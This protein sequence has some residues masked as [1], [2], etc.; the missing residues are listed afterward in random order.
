MILAWV[1][2]VNF[3]A[4]QCATLVYT[5]E[6]QPQTA[7]GYTYSQGW[8]LNNTS[9]CHAINYHLQEWY[10]YTSHVQVS[11][12]GINWDNYTG[13][14][15]LTLGTTS[16]SNQSDP[17]TVY[18]NNSDSAEVHFNFTQC[19]TGKHY[20]IFFDI[21][22]FGSNDPLIPLDEG[23]LWTSFYVENTPPPPTVPNLT[24]YTPSVQSQVIA[25]HNINLSAVIANTGTAPTGNFAIAEIR[26]S[27]NMTLSDA[28]ELLSDPFIASISPGATSNLYQTLTI[29]ASTPAGTYYIFINVDATDEVDETNEND[30]VTYISIEVILS[31]SSLPNLVPTNIFLPS[32]VNQ[33]QNFSTFFKTKNASNNSLSWTYFTG[34]IYL[35]TNNSL[36]SNDPIVKTVTNPYDLSPGEIDFHI[37][38][39]Y[40]NNLSPGNYW[41]IYQVDT[42]N[43]VNETTNDDNV[44]VKPFKVRVPCVQGG[45]TPD[46]ILSSPEIMEGQSINVSNNT[47][48][49]TSYAWN[50]DNTS[51]SSNTNLNNIALENPG[52]AAMTL[53]AYDACDNDNTITEHVKV[54]PDKTKPAPIDARSGYNG[55]SARGL[56]P[57]DLATGAFV[58]KIDFFTIDDFS[59]SYPVSAYYTSTSNEHTGLGHKW[60][61]SFDVRLEAEER[62]YIAHW[63][64]GHKDYYV[65]Y[66]DNSAEPLYNGITDTLYEVGPYI[67]EKPNG[68]KYKFTSGD[69]PL[70]N[71]IE[72]RYGNLIYFSYYSSSLLRK[73]TFPNGKWIEYNYDV[74]GYI[75]S[76]EADDGRE[77]QFTID[78]TNGNLIQYTNVKG[79]AMSM[80]YDASH[81]LVSKTDFKGTTVLANTYDTYNRVVSQTDAY[82]ETFHAAYNTP[83]ADATTVTDPA[84]N[85]TIYY[86][87]NDL[88][89]Y[90]KTDELGFSTYTNYDNVVHRPNS[91]TD[92][93][94]NISSIIFDEIGNPLHIIN[95]LGDSISTTLGEHNLP[96]SFTN[97]L[98]GITSFT[99]D[100]EGNPLTTTLPNGATLASTFSGRG[101]L[102]TYTTPNGYDYS[103]AYDYLGNVTEMTTPSGIINFTRDT[104]GRVLTITDR[105]NKTIEFVWDEKNIIEV[106]DAKGNSSYASYDANDNLLYQVNRSSDTTFYSYDLRDRLVKITNALGEE[107][108]FVYN[109]LDLLVEVIDAKNNTISYT[110]NARKELVSMTND[111][112]TTQYAYN[113]VGDLTSYTTSMGN[114]YLTS[115]DALHR[116]TLTSNPLGKIVDSLTYNKASQPLKRINGSGHTTTFNYTNMG[117]LTKAT[118]N[119]GASNTMTLDNEGN[120]LTLK[121]ANGHITTF[122]YNEF[123]QAVT[124]QTPAGRTTTMTVNNEGYITQ[125][126]RPD[127]T[128]NSFAYDDNYNII[129]STFP[130]DVYSWVYNVNDE[131]TA[132]TN[133]NGTTSF[134][135][136]ALSRI[137][138]TTDPFGNEIFKGYDEVS[139]NIYTVYPSGDTLTTE[140]NSL[141]LATKVSDWLGNYSIREYNADGLLTDITNSNGTTTQIGY[142]NASQ[143][144]SYQN[145]LADESI[146]N[147][148][149][150][151]RLTGGNIAQD[152]AIVPLQPDFSGRIDTYN[153]NPD[154]EIV[155]TSAKNFTHNQ[156]GARSAI[157][158]A[159]NENITWGESDLV[160]SYTRNGEN[161]SNKYNP[162][163]QRIEKNSNS[164][165]T[166]YALDISS[167]LSQIL[168]E[169]DEVGYTNATNIYAPDGLA[170]R[171]DDNGEA[172]FFHFDY[173]G[174][175]KGLTDE[176]GE[177]TDL[178]AH[179][180]FGDYLRHSGASSQPFIFQGKYGITHEGAG[181]YQVRAREYDATTGLFWSKDALNAGLGNT[182]SSTYIFGLNNPLSFVDVDGNMPLRQTPESS[183]ATARVRYYD[184]TRDKFSYKT[185][186]VSNANIMSGILPRHEIREMGSLE[187]IISQ[188]EI[189]NH[190][191]FQGLSEG[192]LFGIIPDKS[193]GSYF[194]GAG[195]NVSR[196][197]G[198][199]LGMVPELILSGNKLAAEFATRIQP[200]K[201]FNKSNYR[202]NLQ[203]LTGNSGHGFD[204]HHIFPQEF[205]VLFQNIGININNPNN[206]KWWA[207]NSHRKNAKAYNQAWS[208]FFKFNP[209]P[210]RRQIENFGTHIMNLFGF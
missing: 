192:F 202:Y 179:S 135:L 122:T 139:N 87:D 142:D 97:L 194:S 85:T 51:S 40:T 205:Q 112:G 113:A 42:H 151:T 110:Y 172:S 94:G 103:L 7:T 131:M 71:Q 101:Q 72:D 104:E 208:S 190:C 184:T 29:D 141:G 30:N 21:Y 105:E 20:K 196:N 199:F 3:L 108:Q 133:V 195:C 16:P 4:A 76:I 17:F 43:N 56:D 143:I 107:T 148:H 169:Q 65:R 111:L 31:S 136:D 2:S 153:H 185:I 27:N 22:P 178:Y 61:Y 47:T 37:G 18:A 55:N 147:Q 23:R 64:D 91:F 163:R 201:T 183:T 126:Q 207:Y 77:V 26:L 198:E 187:H 166:R 189:A 130:E 203:A 1:A 88:R 165:T 13:A 204:A 9:S 66:Q 90:K 102:L 180:P 188:A 52:S 115:Y 129:S 132:M 210:T 171:I 144:V 176:S 38:V 116:P 99:R 157:S 19:E 25:G 114:T 134:E 154:D 49:A 124:Q 119:L 46:F 79:D 100:S 24:V 161:I 50:I 93:L 182:Q 74:N 193:K 149:N 59:G 168:E 92:E 138:K 33:G 11:D 60:T 84:G 106:V 78:G 140:F 58:T 118:D 28:D 35:S 95:A 53:T 160:T 68:T 128:I 173:I 159:T 5:G 170:W 120:I 69:Q 62:R 155:S 67:I 167:Y 48:N 145:L 158:G 137:T 34:T 8:N 127:G 63:P 41:M 10:D 36:D 57:V 81:N 39:S 181:H 45:P 6:Y 125:V 123:G 174:H 75:T 98:G 121:D 109:N 83:I 73:V 15:N 12:D 206:L 86:H 32:V 54:R 197:I 14:Y 156:N 150:L 162:L 191:F 186:Q 82:N 200:L 96:L 175:T 164:E 44:I 152:A 70:L 80:V 117:W 89:L 177:T 209:Y 146:L